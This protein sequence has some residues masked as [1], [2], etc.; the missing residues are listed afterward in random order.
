[1]KLSRSEQNSHPFIVYVL[2]TDE[3]TNK[4]K[5]YI[6]KTNNFHCR[7]REHCNRKCGA[8]YTKRYRDTHN[9]VPGLTVHGFKDE[10]Q[11]LQFEYALQNPTRSR[12]Y[13]KPGFVGRN[14]ANTMR[15]AFNLIQFSKRYKDMGLFI[16]IHTSHPAL[17][18]SLSIQALGER[19]FLNQSYYEFVNTLPI[20]PFIK[21]EKVISKPKVRRAQPI[22]T[23]KI[24]SNTTPGVVIGF[25]QPTLA[26]T[27]ALAK[28]KAEKTRLDYQRS[29]KSIT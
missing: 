21:E 24:Y 28:Q 20:T 4:S 5:I 14:Y 25:T 10:T 8:K 6:G 23:K 2:R 1:M 15:N 13:D 11:S 12:A 22:P 26:Q 9:W 29:I 27:I 17:L 19:V 16:A 7:Y 3:Q 18:N